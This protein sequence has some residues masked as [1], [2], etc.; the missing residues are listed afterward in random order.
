M[1]RHLSKGHMPVDL[2][3]AD[4]NLRDDFHRLSFFQDCRRFYYIT[5]SDLDNRHLNCVYAGGSDWP[6]LPP[7]PHVLQYMRMTAYLLGIMTA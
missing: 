7:W 6:R 4:T 5:S 1:H 3:C 2:A